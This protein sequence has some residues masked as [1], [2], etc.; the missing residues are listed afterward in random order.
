M[1]SYESYMWEKCKQHCMALWVSVCLGVDSSTSH[2]NIT[3]IY[4]T[5]FEI[6]QFLL[7]IF[8]CAY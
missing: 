4:R 2:I 8:I 1:L 7:L 6:F 3:D 5:K